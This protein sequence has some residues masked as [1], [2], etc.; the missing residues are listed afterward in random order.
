[1]RFIQNTDA[2]DAFAGISANWERL[3]KIASD[4]LGGPTDKAGAVAF[5]KGHPNAVSTINGH[6]TLRSAFRDP[7]F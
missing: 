7:R 6:I 4:S 5:L 1:M 2:I 3:V